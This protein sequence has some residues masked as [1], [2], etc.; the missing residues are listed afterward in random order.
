MREKEMALRE[1]VLLQLLPKGKEVL[2]MNVLNM[3]NAFLA[4]LFGIVLS[5]AYSPVITPLIETIYGAG[6]LAGC[7]GT[8]ATYYIAHIGA[9]SIV[10]ILVMMFP[11]VI[12]LDDDSRLKLKRMI[13]G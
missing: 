4:S 2:V 9:L 12:A 1:R 3:F 8:C 13:G 11:I 5:V 10:F 6:G 7:N